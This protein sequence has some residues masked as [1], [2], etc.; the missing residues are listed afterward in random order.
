MFLEG[1]S[2]EFSSAPFRTLCKLIL[3]FC[4]IFW[5]FDVFLMNHV[6]CIIFW[7]DR[8]FF[9]WIDWRFGNMF[10]LLFDFLRWKFLFLLGLFFLNENSFLLRLLWWG[11][12]LGC[13]LFELRRFIQDEF[14]LSTWWLIEFEAGFAIELILF[15]WVC[16]LTFQ[17]VLAGFLGSRG[18]LDSA[19]EESG[20]GSAR[21][22][23]HGR[24][25]SGIAFINESQWFGDLLFDRTRNY[26][27][28]IHFR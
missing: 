16:G 20:G 13:F 19:F 26:W 5:L 17:W 6:F 10:W 7:S 4:N 3:V 12:Q 24:L 23:G 1:F 8:L 28:Q 22:N 15:I 25:I 9:D 2:V 11:F 21:L 14:E 27:I 18:P